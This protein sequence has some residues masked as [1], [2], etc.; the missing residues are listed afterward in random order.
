MNNTHTAYQT[1]ITTL[2]DADLNSVESK[3][4]LGKSTLVLA[5]PPCWH[6]KDMEETTPT[7]SEV[8][9]TS[10]HEGERTVARIQLHHVL[11]SRG[12]WHGETGGRHTLL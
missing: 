3:V 10:K 2:A 5:P 7:N 4:V 6:Y 8:T 12:V 1:D 11:F 9:T